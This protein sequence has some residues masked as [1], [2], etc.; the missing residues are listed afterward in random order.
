MTFDDLRSGGKRAI[1]NALTRIETGPDAAETALLLDAAFL[2]PKGNVLGLT[3][4]PG[5]GKSTLID[6]L[7][8]I[9]RRMGKTIA[10]VAIDPS[11][12]QTHGALLGDRTRLNT[13]P[14]DAGVF[15]RSMAARDRLGGVAETTFPATVLLRACFDLVI[16]ETVGVGQSETEITDVADVTAYLAQPGSGDALQFMKAGI[17]EVPD[18]FVVTKSDVGAPA[19]QTASDLRGALSLYSDAELPVLTCSA[20]SG[21]GLNDLVHAICT[22]IGQLSPRFANRRLR[23][24]DSWHQRQILHRFGT[25]G[26]RLLVDRMPEPSTESPFATARTRQTRLSDALGAAFQ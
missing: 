17:M 9:W 18:L 13:D 14:T 5:V 16:V 2:Q 25:D 10:V 24:V 23:Q 12:L 15:V 7:I 21:A 4:P 26:Y 8:P 11:S 20:A 1:A 6:G 3:G 22:T 19:R